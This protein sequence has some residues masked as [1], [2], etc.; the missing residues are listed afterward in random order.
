MTTFDFNDILNE[1]SKARGENKES[2]RLAGNYNVEVAYASGST[3]KKDGTKKNPTVSV[4]FIVLDGPQVGDETWLNVVLTEKSKA[5]FGRT[6]LDLGVP[7]MF[8]RSLG[9]ASSEDE[10]AAKLTEI[11][12]TL[13]GARYAVTVGPNTKSP[14]FDSWIFN[15]IVTAPEVPITVSEPPVTAHVIPGYVPPLPTAVLSD[16]SEATA[17]TLPGMPGGYVPQLTN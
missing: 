5:A 17:L 15:T 3:R 8:L 6:L 2:V 12:E 9:T 7:E 13:P 14:D 10:I 1:A 4:K 16:T 11:A